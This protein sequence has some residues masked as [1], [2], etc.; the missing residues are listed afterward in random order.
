MPGMSRT[1]ALG[2]TRLTVVAALTALFLLTAGSLANPHRASAATDETIEAKILSLVNAA[3]KARGIEPLRVRA[4]LVDFAGDRAAY[5]ASTGVLKHPSCLSCRL[6][7]RGIS[8]ETYGETIAWTFAPWG[9]EAARSLFRIWKN[10]PPHW[11]ILMSSRLDSVGIG[12]ARR[13]N[14]S[15]WAAAVLTG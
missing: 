1:T 14:G 5:M 8:Y 13:A 6:D 7:R 11:S 12:V 15:T 4:S 2:R 10:S 9:D 3:R